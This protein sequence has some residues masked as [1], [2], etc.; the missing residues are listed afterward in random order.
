ML[1]FRCGSYNSDEAQ[2]CTVCG[3]ELVDKAGKKMNV[4]YNAET[5]DKVDN[6]EA[7]EN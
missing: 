4:A 3:Q 1:C 6:V 5:L 7:G 2:K